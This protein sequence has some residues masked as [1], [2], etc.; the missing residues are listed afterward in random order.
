MVN[1]DSEWTEIGSNMTLI[2]S[3]L[4]SDCTNRNIVE[5]KF[6]CDELQFLTPVPYLVE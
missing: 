3:L 5:N 2:K 6:L 1:A 4:F